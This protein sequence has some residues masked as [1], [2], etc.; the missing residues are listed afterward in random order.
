MLW[1]L[2]CHTPSIPLTGALSLVQ[3]GR[4]EVFELTDKRLRPLWFKASVSSSSDQVAVLGL[5]LVSR[6]CSD[7]L[8]VAVPHIQHFSDRRAF[9][10]AGGSI[11]GFREL[12][13][14][15]LRPLWFKMSVLFCPHALIAHAWIWLSPSASPSN[16]TECSF[17]IE[18]LAHCHWEKL[19][20]H[21][22]YSTI[23]AS[24]K[25]PVLHMTLM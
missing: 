14:K 20:S 2:Q 17:L 8:A 25:L 6:P 5:D 21:A 23:N 7:A 1:R 16:I 3:E 4:S 24:N 18:R 11:G 22:S 13:D 19:V 12:T 9:A 15:R 10:G